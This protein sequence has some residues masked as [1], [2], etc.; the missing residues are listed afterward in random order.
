ML[1]L[2][3]I[4]NQLGL[5]G[6]GASSYAAPDSAYSP[7]A[8]TGS[9][10]PPGSTGS[11]TGMDKILPQLDQQ[12]PLATGLGFNVGTGQLAL[13]GLGSLANIFGGLKAGKLA[14]DQFKFTKAVT[15]TN[16]NNQLQS[17]NTALSD[18]A[19][20]RGVAE[21][22]STAE[23]QAYIDKNRLTRS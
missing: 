3:D 15:N 20:A 13:A 8:V 9:I 21:G 16:L 14:E 19:R 6:T 23:V 10:T 7:G 12:N 2:Q 18:R 1:T 5:L 11:M 17:Y 22:Q 4:M